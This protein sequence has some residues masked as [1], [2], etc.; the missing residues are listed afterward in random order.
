MAMVERDGDI[1]VARIEKLPGRKLRDQLETNVARE[2]ILMTDE[3][4]SYHRCD[5]KFVRHEAVN[6]SKGEYARRAKDRPI[7]H[8]NTA[9]SFSALLK[10]GHYGTFHQL[11]K[12]HLHRYCTEFGFRWAFRNVTDGERMVAAM[13]DAEGKPLMYRVSKDGNGLIQS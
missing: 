10:R 6:H 11:S 8:G 3:S 4:A 9:E 1:R 5:R 13:K 12:K 7:A 2:A